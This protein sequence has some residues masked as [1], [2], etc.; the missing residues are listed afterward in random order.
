MRRAIAFVAFVLA[1]AAG[2][3]ASGARNQAL[4]IG[5]SQYAELEN[6]RYA[7][8]DA[9]KL[10]QLLTDFGGYDKRDVTLVL[11]QEATKA[12][13]ARELDRIIRESEKEPFDH[14]LLMFAG[15]GIYKRIDDL[16]THSF[17]APA[18]ASTADNTFYT[19]GKESVN[20][21]FISR[22]W[23]ARQLTL[24]KARSIVIIIDSCYSG[25]KE[26]GTLFL[27]NLGYNVQSFGGPGGRGVTVATRALVAERKVAY[28][29]SA[30]DNQEAAEYDELRHGALS[31]CIFEYVARARREIYEDERRDL[32]VEAVYS[33]VNT[34]F[35]ETKVKGAVLADVHQPV[36]FAIP[37]SRAVQNMA[38]FSIQ[39]ARKREAAPALGMLDVSTQQVVAEISVDGVK[40]SEA[41]EGRIAIPEGKHHIEL[42]VP[43]TAYRISF[44]A[45][46]S[47]AQPVTEMVPMYGSLEVESFYLQDGR[48]TP[49]P[50]LDVFLNGDPVGKSNLKL[51]RLLAGSHM[52]EVRFQG[53]SKRRQV[54]IRPDS[55]LRVNYSVIREAAPV[56]KKDDKGVGNVVF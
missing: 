27:Q 11:N 37:D 40:R 44:T 50:A 41:A 39:G 32:T 12:R 6:L 5:I 14:F 20:E 9:S 54:E 13:I 18:D 3:E 38:F 56:P 22:A 4:L 28:L 16:E 49:G 42:F 48:R 52:L 36:M 46:I 29:A 33:N 8:A 15:H 43:Q 26:F 35:R 23:L 1:A 21:S 24:I 47:A 19:T 31:F 25:T 45:N 53:V 2:G 55:P 51:T 30:R 7:D 34:L 17:L 10:S